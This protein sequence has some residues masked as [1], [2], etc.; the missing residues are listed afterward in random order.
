[1]RR[2]PDPAV[3]AGVAEGSE[4]AAGAGG[5]LDGVDEG[6]PVGVVGDDEAIWDADAGGFAEVAD[7]VFDP[8]EGFGFDDAVEGV[9]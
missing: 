7:G 6:V 1:M 5:V 3:G 2:A 9:G 8:L 4:D